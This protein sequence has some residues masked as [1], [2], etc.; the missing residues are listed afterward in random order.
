MSSDSRILAYVASSGPQGMGTIRCYALN[1][2]TGALEFLH[3][4]E[5]VRN[6][7]FLVVHPSKR[8][9]Y[10]VNEIGDYQGQSAGALSAFA[11]DPQTCKLTLLNQQSTLGAGPCFVGL[12]NTARYAMISNFGAGSIAIYPIRADGS[13]AAA[14]DTVQHPTLGEK[15]PHAHS[16]RMDPANRIA[17]VCD[18]GLDR[19]LF[20]RVDLEHGKLTPNTQPY[21][22]LAE[23]AGPRHSEFHPIGYPLPLCSLL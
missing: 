5:E 6:P 21:L 11:I 15:Y 8:F 14:S 7:S 16:I 4:S 22:Q 3:Q 12:D 17:I 18:L 1:L 19:V 13:L 10:C 23:G 2:A 9:L 20:Y